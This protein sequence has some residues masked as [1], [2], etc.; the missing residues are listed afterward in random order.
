MNSSSESDEL[1][2]EMHI[3]SKTRRLGFKSGPAI[4]PK[5]RTIKRSKGKKG[6]GHGF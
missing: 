4:G 6:D 2:E 1:S 3:E 5:N